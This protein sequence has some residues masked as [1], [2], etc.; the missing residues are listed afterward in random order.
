MAQDIDTSSD[1]S[2]DTESE[3]S[4]DTNS[5]FDSDIAGDEGV[6][7]NAETEEYAK[8]ESSEFQKTGKIKQAIAGGLAFI[9]GSTALAFNRDNSNHTDISP[10]QSWQQDVSMDDIGTDLENDMTRVRETEE[11]NST[12]KEPDYGEYDDKES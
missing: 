4:N 3:V 6:D 12:S 8:Q 1:I 10:A 7:L 9:A 5:D 11:Q 2:P